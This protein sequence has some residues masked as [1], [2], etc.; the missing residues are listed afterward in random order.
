MTTP[1]MENQPD[2]PFSSQT[3]D[4]IDLRQIFGALVRRKVLIAKITAATVLLTGLYAFSRKPIWEGSFQI[5][6]EN[7]RN[8]SV[9]RLAQFAATNPM[10]SNLAGLSVGAG[11]SS[12]ET[13]VKILES[14][15][16]LKPIYDFVRKSKA[17]VSF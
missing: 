3:G 1:S 9:G 5:L 7:Q 16:V 6:V 13:E 15:S 10:L 4:E 8:G 14:P 17:S 11:E 2:I 12:L